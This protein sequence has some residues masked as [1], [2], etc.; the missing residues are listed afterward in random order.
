MSRL[1][2]TFAALA[3]AGGLALSA[4]VWMRMSLR[5]EYARGEEHGAQAARA[6][7]SDMAAQAVA[8]AQTEAARTQAVLVALE[9]ERD[10]MQERID[11]L[12]HAVAQ[13]EASGALPREPVCLEPGLVR[14]LD[15]I[16]R[17][18]LRARAGP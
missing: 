3:F 9:D 10:L 15:A 12:E 18:D 8:R 17:P 5:A 4:A 6:L 7:A 1:T 13:A 14:A 2:L 16:R 11:A